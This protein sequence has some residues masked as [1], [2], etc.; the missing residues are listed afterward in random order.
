MSWGPMIPES[1]GMPAA[2]VAGKMMKP[3]IRA[4]SVSMAMMF[5]AAFGRL[6]LFLK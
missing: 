5:I 4:I 6:V 2:D 3:A 1:R